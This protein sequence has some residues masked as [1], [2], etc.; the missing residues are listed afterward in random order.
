M[1]YKESAGAKWEIIADLRCDNNFRKIRIPRITANTKWPVIEIELGGNWTGSSLDYADLLYLCRNRQNK[2]MIIHEYTSLESICG[3]K[4]F[5]HGQGH[6][7]I[8][9][10][11][12]IKNSTSSVCS[13]ISKIFKDFEIMV[14]LCLPICPKILLSDRRLK[15]LPTKKLVQNNQPKT[16]LKISILIKASFFEMF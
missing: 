10:N 14:I 12:L 9:N 16:T 3:Q 8:L 15:N 6:L 7:C 1:R 2:C 5:G 4:K 13:M 11:A